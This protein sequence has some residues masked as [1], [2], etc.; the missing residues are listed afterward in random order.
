MLQAELMPLLNGR[1]QVQARLGTPVWLVCIL[2]GTYLIH[3]SRTK[4]QLSLEMDTSLDFVVQFSNQN[5]LYKNEYIKG[6]CTQRY[7]N[8]I[9]KCIASGEMACRSILGKIVNNSAYISRK[10]MKMCR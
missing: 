3:T 2:K 6:K 8:N 7:E 4:V 1:D 5:D 10:Q 9:Q